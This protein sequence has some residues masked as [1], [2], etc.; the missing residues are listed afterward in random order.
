[1]SVGEARG[2]WE[3]PIDLEWVATVLEG[4]PMRSQGALLD[5]T[6][7]EVVHSSMIDFVA[8]DG[9]GFATM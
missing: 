5:L 8:A 9:E 3:L 2:L 6:T 1:M 7:G 4:D